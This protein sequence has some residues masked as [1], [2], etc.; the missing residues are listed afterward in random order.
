MEL[1]S[2]NYCEKCDQYS[3][4]SE[5][6]DLLD[7]PSR[8]TQTRGDGQRIVHSIPSKTLRKETLVSFIPRHAG[9]GSPLLLARV[10][11][12]GVRS[13]PRVSQIEIKQLFS[14]IGRLIIE[15]ENKVIKARHG[16]VHKAQAVRSC[17]R[18]MRKIK[19][20][21]TFLSKT[22]KKQDLLEEQTKA[23]LAF[24]CRYLKIQKIIGDMKLTLAGFKSA[25][26][27]QRSRLKIFP[28]ISTAHSFSTPIEPP[29]PIPKLV[30]SSIM[31]YS[32]SAT[33]ATPSISSVT[34]ERAV[35]SAVTIAS[36]RTAFNKHLYNGGKL[37]TQAETQMDLIQKKNGVGSL[38]RAREMVM[39]CKS[40]SA[41]MRNYLNYKSL[42]DPFQV[43][44]NNL[45]IFERNVGM[46]MKRIQFEMTKRID[47]GK[48]THN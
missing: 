38:F 17:N 18:K 33:T 19:K 41:Q 10:S 8:D 2:I 3:Q 28:A 39:K 12:L 16:D 36:Q 21:N 14:R 11:R 22:I 23:Y 27:A 35:L 40:E 5:M 43:F 13:L 30:V 48:T 7:S 25:R 26:I 45:M 47:T 20:I 42:I 1:T 31:P 37:L 24:K 46:L 15:S 9:P 6:P 44:E 32:V 34:A 29:S 4:I